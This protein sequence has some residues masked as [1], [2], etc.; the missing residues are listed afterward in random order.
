MHPVYDL[1]TLSI[2]LNRDYDDYAHRPL[3]VT[4]EDE[5]AKTQQILRIRSVIHDTILGVGGFFTL[6]IASFHR[7]IHHIIIFDRGARVAHFWHAA[8]KII[9]ES[10]DRLEVI[11]KIKMLLRTESEYYF[12][13]DGIFSDSFS[14]SPKTVAGRE[15]VAFDEAV[16]SN[17]SWLSDQDRFENIKRI[18]KNNCFYFRRV[19]LFN[20]RSMECFKR[21]LDAQNIKLDMAYL[22]NIGEYCVNEEDYQRGIAQILLP[23]T[24]VISAH[25]SE[26]GENAMQSIVIREQIPIKVLLFPTPDQFYEHRLTFSHLD[27]SSGW[28]SSL[29]IRRIQ[30][31]SIVVLPIILYTLRYT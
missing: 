28:L 14:D 29:S 12:R 8:E 23:E 30:C 31:I 21:L 24:A 15:C 3:V 6:D 18:F 4:N 19:D 20:R 1:S 10:D 17:Y 25:F 7:K 9:S 5:Q 16:E 22:S 27:S 2:P 11:Q 26:P 13:N